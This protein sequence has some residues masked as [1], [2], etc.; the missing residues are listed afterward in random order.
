M[1][2]ILHNSVK[3]RD[4]KSF[5]GNRKPIALG[6]DFPPWSDGHFSPVVIG[7]VWKKSMKKFFDLLLGQLCLANCS[8]H[9][10]QKLRFGAIILNSLSALFCAR[11]SRFYLIDI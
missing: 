9:S 4:W 1:N 11:G 8:A 2:G 10:R 3:P 7:A 5:G 6:T